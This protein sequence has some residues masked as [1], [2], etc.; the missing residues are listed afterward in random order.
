MNILQEIAIR[1]KKRVE[2][3]KK[4]LPRRFRKRVVLEAGVRQGW[5]GF[6][7]ELG[8]FVGMDGFGASGKSS[9]LAR[10]FGFTREAVMERIKAAGYLDAPKPP[11]PGAFVR[12]APIDD[13]MDVEELIEEI[14]EAADEK[15]EN[16]DA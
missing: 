8:I 4:V 14:K 1:T 15:E 16:S 7:G 2:D 12:A 9:D 5:E 10:H 3:R 13:V 11:Q 6:L